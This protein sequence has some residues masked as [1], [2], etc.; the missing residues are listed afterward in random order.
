MRRGGGSGDERGGSAL[1]HRWCD[2][3]SCCGSGGWLWWCCAGRVRS[4]CRRRVRGCERVQLGMGCLPTQRGPP[5][6]CR[7]HCSHPEIAGLGSWEGRRRSG[8]IAGDA[9]RRRRC[10]SHTHTRARGQQRRNVR[11]GSVTQRVCR[12]PPF[13]HR[14]PDRSHAHSELC[15]PHPLSRHGPC[16]RSAS[17]WAARR[18]AAA[19]FILDESGPFS[20]SR[21]RAD[22]RWT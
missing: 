1:V 4:G 8:S 22:R 3:S 20:K 11:H 2:R 18:A 19:A 9:Q 10:T 5:P 15:P 6:P 14:R 21:R 16:P 13:L 7:N 17:L 12:R